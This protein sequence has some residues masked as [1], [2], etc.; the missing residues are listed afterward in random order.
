MSASVVNSLQVERKL[1]S[2]DCYLDYWTIGG[3]AGRVH[4]PGRGLQAAWDWLCIE[5]DLEL[6]AVVLSLFPKC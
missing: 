4:T 5:N 6:T 3:A 1:Q 2:L